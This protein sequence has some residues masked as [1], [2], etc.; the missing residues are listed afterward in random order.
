MQARTFYPA[1][2]SFRTEGD[3]KSFPDKQKLKE[4]ITTKPAL[5]EILKG[6]LSGKETIK[7]TV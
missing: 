7:V 4:F 2:L 1:R 3:R 5:Q 6:T